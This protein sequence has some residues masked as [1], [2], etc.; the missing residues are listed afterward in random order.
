MDYVILSSLRA[1]GIIPF[2]I[3]LTYDIACQYFKNFWTRMNGL[4]EGIKPK[5][6]SSQLI[7]K[8]PKGH[9]VGH[10]PQCHGPF[11]LNYT[12][13]A[14]RTDGEG[15][16]RRWAILNRTAASVREMTISGRREVIDDVCGHANWVKM[17]T[18]GRFL[19][20]LLCS[21]LCQ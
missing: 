5:F 1:F 21:L 3:V 16:E 18:L 17:M 2:T 12:T 9:L 14:G 6:S 19:S 15:I 20:H 13:G 8:V 7:G 4:P 10:G 11:S